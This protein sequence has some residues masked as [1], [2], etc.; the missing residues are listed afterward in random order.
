MGWFEFFVL[1]FT[2]EK[3]RSRVFAESLRVNSASPF[4]AVE[5]IKPL[6]ISKTDGAFIVVAFNQQQLNTLP[7]AARKQTN[8]LNYQPAYNAV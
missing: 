1:V 3:R 4:S 8:P 7:L 6:P 5:L 2:A